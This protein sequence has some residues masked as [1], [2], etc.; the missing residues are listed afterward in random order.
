MGANAPSP[1]PSPAPPADPVQQ[2]IERIRDTVRWLLTG[3]AAV[4]AVLVT[5]LSLSDV[6]DADTDVRGAVLGFGLAI[7]GLV[8]AAALAGL[9]LAG[10][11]LLTID[12]VATSKEF[13][14]LRS[15]ILASPAVRPF[16]GEGEGLSDLPGTLTQAVA[17]RRAAVDAAAAS[18]SDATVAVVQLRDQQVQE[19]NNALRIALAEAKLF[20]AARR[21]RRLGAGMAVAV[22]V[23]ALGAFVFVRALGDPAVP[24]TAPAL[25]RAPTSVVLNLSES[26]RTRLA[27]ALGTDCVKAKVPAVVVEQRTA[28]LLNVAVAKGTTCNAALVLFEL[29][30]DGTFDED[31]AEAEAS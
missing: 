11:R 22:A 17:V 4:G 5:G 23:V 9:V 13:A 27:G 16:L 3:F 25:V 26:G 24:K 14:E 31:A 30:V 18:L 20:R 1:S 28:T 7:T 21:F 8:V 6:R 15:R 29:G 19:L 12:E 2:T 10:D